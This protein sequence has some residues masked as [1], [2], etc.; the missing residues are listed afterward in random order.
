MFIIFKISRA[1]L[2]AVVFATKG[3]LI[4]R[5]LKVSG[6]V[7]LALGALFVPNGSAQAKGILDYL[8]GPLYEPIRQDS[9]Y[10]IRSIV[11]ND[12]KWATPCFVCSF[13]LIT[14]HIIPAGQA[15]MT[16]WFLGL[17]HTQL[18][19]LVASSILVTWIVLVLVFWSACLHDLLRAMLQRSSWPLKNVFKRIH[20]FSKV[21]THCSLLHSE[22]CEAKACCASSCES[23]GWLSRRNEVWLSYKQTSLSDWL[24][25]NKH[26]TEISR[27]LIQFSWCCIQ[28]SICLCNLKYAFITVIES[29]IKS[30][31]S[32]FDAEYSRYWPRK[33]PLSCLCPIYIH[34]HLW[35]MAVYSLCFHAILYACAG[36]CA[37]GIKHLL[38]S[39]TMS[40]V[41]LF[42]FWFGMAFYE[43][44]VLNNSLSLGEAL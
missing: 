21:V 13:R 42:L 41:S 40:S 43:D 33:T 12:F 38:R 27:L 18:N 3:V 16:D 4:W 9:P 7:V 28:I 26:R 34:R 10:W 15:S 44:E 17:I 5:F 8:T 29:N 19:Q 22:W 14:T 1:L 39:I 2:K 35:M 11:W 20:C 6:G 31:E 36:T 23:L 32:T 30:N 24:K 25:P 37:L